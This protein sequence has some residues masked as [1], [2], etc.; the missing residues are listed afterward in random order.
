MHN[1]NEK[2]CYYDKLLHKVS[3]DWLREFEEFYSTKNSNQIP[4]FGLVKVN[5]MSHDYLERLF[6]IDQ[7]LENLLKSLFTE[8]FLNNTLFILMGISLRF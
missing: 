6:W 1:S 7:D 5:E 8:Q 3:F 4:R 2:P